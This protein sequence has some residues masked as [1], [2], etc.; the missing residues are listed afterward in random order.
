MFLKKAILIFFLLI[1]SSY[2]CLSSLK[3]QTSQVQQLAI[4]TPIPTNI[5]S[6]HLIKAFFVEQAP[7]RNWDQPWQDACEEASLLTVD[8]YYRHQKPSKKHIVADILKMIDYQHQQNW[9]KDINIEQMAYLSQDYLSY[10]TEIID[11]PTIKQLKNF[12]TKNIPIIVPANGKILYQENKHFTHGGPYYHNL[13]ILGYNDSKQQFTVHDVGTKHGAYFKYS[14]NLLLKS[15][16]DLPDSG[17]KQDINS[18]PAKVL[19]LLP[20]QK[21]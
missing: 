9:T 2:F 18:A 12:L 3:P 8:Y 15:I 10:Q 17:H 13:V 4:D 5:P 6:S 14:Y 11:Q 16:H 20:N 21:T 1:F 19:I 7:Q